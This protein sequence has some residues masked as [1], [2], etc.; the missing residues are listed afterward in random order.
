VTDRD[1]NPRDVPEVTAG[2]LVL[3]GGLLALVCDWDSWVSRRVDSFWFG[4]DDERVLNRQQSMDFRLPEMA[5]RFGPITHTLGGVPV[6]I[7]FVDKWRLP[8]FSL[9]DRCGNA[10]SVL[11]RHEAAPIVAGMLIGLGHYVLKGELLPDPSE[12]MPRSVRERLIEIVIADSGDAVRLCA[13]LD[14]TTLHPGT[15]EESW[16]HVGLANS[17]IFMGLAYELARGFL[18]TALYPTA[19]ESHQVLKF[20]YDAY[21]VPTRHDRKSV[22]VKHG[23]RALGQGRRDTTESTDWATGVGLRRWKPRTAPRG[24]SGEVVLSTVSDTFPITPREG[25]RSVACAFVRLRSVTYPEEHHRTMRLRAGTTLSVRNLPPAEYELR[26]EGCSGFRVVPEGPLRF[27]VSENGIERVHI[28]ACRDRQS[29]TPILAQPLIERPASR[30]RTISRAFGWHSKPVVFRVRVGDGGSYHCE[31]E[32]PA[33][34]QVTRARLISNAD[35]EGRELDLV[36]ESTPR[37]H[38]Y[39]PAEKTRPAAA[40]VLLNLRPQVETIARPAFWTACAASTILLFLALLWNAQHGLENHSPTDGTTLLV[41]L[42]GAPSAL[43]AY[44]AQAVPSRVTNSILYG[45]R[46]AALLPASLSI[47]AAGVVLVGEKHRHWEWSYFALW[48][49]FGLSVLTVM[50]LWLTQWLA[51]HPREQRF[52]RRTVATGSSPASAK[53]Q[54]GS[55]AA[56]A[57]AATDEEPPNSSEPDRRDEVRDRMLAR[58]HGLATQTRKE[59]F[60]QAGILR[61]S[62]RIPPAQYFDSAETPP[63]FFGV[64][65]D[66][67]LTRLRS[68]VHRLMNSPTA[69]MKA[70]NV[71]LLAERRKRRTMR[72]EATPEEST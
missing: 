6:P 44:F 26:I 67:D 43:A 68:Q 16:W 51:Q 13:E 47:A 24:G 15:S 23:L 14:R 37:T 61:E 35:G 40:Y 55:L 29:G 33:G 42:L 7:T 70:L 8:Q 49:I 57:N 63:S 46:L 53:Q 60:A 64:E 9:R 1:S 38:L 65:S 28:R 71:A 20:E 3:G 62:V 27:E 31:F 12:L 59:L 25:G 39:A 56:A 11:S 18:L 58:G 17:E 36:L 32:A 52:A 41:I 10:V 22:R 72:G 50:M 48:L 21:R 54:A 2:H 19:P 34:L 45:L 69:R 66:G 5:S 30:V 4:G